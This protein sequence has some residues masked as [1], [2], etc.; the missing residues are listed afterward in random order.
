MVFVTTL[1]AALTASAKA[2]TA[3]ARG[4]ASSR[5]RW[6]GKAPS[7]GRLTIRPHFRM[8]PIWHLGRFDIRL[9]LRMRSVQTSNFVHSGRV[10]FSRG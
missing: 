3:E 1:K 5:L 8:R 7:T 9:A 6:G 10:C 4:W 2:M